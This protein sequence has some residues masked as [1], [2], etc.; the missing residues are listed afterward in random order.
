MQFTSKKEM[1]FKVSKGR[2]NRLQGRKQQRKE[3]KGN[4]KREDGKIMSVLAAILVC[5]VDF[6]FTSSDI[7]PA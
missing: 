5:V 1:V 3:R 6:T 7:N 4:K 2:K